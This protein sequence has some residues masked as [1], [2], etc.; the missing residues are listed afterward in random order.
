MFF[1]FDEP[2]NGLV[3]LLG[4]VLNYIGGSGGEGGESGQRAAR[5]CVLESL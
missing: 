1:A 2:R 3:N 4:I 5:E